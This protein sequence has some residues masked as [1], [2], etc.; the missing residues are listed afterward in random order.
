MPEPIPLNQ[1]SI[2]AVLAL[3]NRDNNS[4]ETF[5]TISFSPVSVAPLIVPRNSTIVVS[6]VEGSGRYGTVQV[7]YNRID[8]ENAFPINPIY[9]DVGEDVINTTYDLLPIINQVYN[10]HLDHEDVILESVIGNTHTIK[11]TSGSYAW[12]G[13]IGVDWSGQNLPS[14]IFLD[15]GNG[16]LFGAEPMTLLNLGAIG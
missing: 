1:P 6:A 15:V 2:D 16:D 14:G 7:Y 5:N 4:N 11:A 8:F 13:E 3:L 10:L 12:L 9:L